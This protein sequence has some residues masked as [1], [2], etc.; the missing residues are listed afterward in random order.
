MLNKNVFPV[1]VYLISQ[2]HFIMLQIVLT[3]ALSTVTI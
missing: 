3:S 2:G 1:F